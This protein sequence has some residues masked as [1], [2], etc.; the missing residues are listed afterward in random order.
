VFPAFLRHRTRPG[1]VWYAG[2]PR[3]EGVTNPLWALVIG[4]LHVLASFTELRLG[5]FVVALNA[6]LLAAWPLVGASHA[7]QGHNK[8]DDNGVFDRR[9]SEFSWTKPAGKHKRD[10]VP[11]TYKQQHFFVLRGTPL[12]RW[13]LLH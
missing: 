13:D 6:L 2:A 11:V 8:A 12:A 5:L 3:V 10:Y 1:L 7:E 9:N 4:T